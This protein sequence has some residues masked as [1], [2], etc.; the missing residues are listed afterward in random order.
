M[1]II[2][3]GNGNILCEMSDNEVRLITHGEPNA[4]VDVS[5]MM[6][7]SYDICTMFTKLRTIENFK[8]SDD[9]G[10]VRREIKDLL[11]ALEP[12]EDFVTKLNAIK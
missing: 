8:V 12:I 2:A 4:K 6:G 9:F 1:K 5:S 7:K 10:S 11:Y 3:R